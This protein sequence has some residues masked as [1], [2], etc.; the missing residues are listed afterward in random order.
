M[1]K[2]LIAILVVFVIAGCGK[3]NKKSVQTQKKPRSVKYMVAKNEGVEYSRVFSGNI[4]SEM[5]SQLSFRVNGTVENKFFKLGDYVK[6]G[7]I[8]SKLDDEDYRLSVENSLAQYESSLA[9][10]AQADANLKSKEASFINSKNEFSRM[11]NLYFDDNVSKSDYDNAKADR[12]VTEAE[13]AE[14]KANKNS[15]LAT[16]RAS[17]IQLTQDRLNLSYTKLIAPADGFISSEDSETNE[18][19]S[20][21]TPIYTMSFGDTLETETFIPENLVGK[22]KKGQE[23]D[24]EVSALSGKIYRGRVKEIASS[25]NGYGNSYPLKVT[26]LEGDDLLKPGMSTKITFNIYGDTENNIVLPLSAIDQDPSG[27]NFIYVLTDIKDGIATVKKEVISLG[28]IYSEGITITKG[29]EAG[30]HIIFA[31]VSQ[32][33]EGQRVSVSSKGGK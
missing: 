3:K 28:K 14:A 13:L 30:D 25:S 12:D 4:I 16:L 6:K 31:G 19:V 2:I 17:E 11:E 20:A 24:V 29:V 21:G 27:N 5:E 23:V 10:V 1:K 18:T 7:D 33:T 22:L 32:I 9:G 8:L 26:L 15:S